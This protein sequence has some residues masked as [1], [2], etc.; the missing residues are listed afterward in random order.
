[1]EE[2]KT[3]EA[4]AERRARKLADI[5]S[6]MLEVIHASLLKLG[7]DLEDR[8]VADPDEP[9]NRVFVRGVVVTPADLTK[10]IDKVQLI[11][12]Q[13][14]SREEHLGLNIHADASDLPPD[15]L[16]DLARVARS[17]GAGA[18][19]VGQSPLPLAEGPIKVN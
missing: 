8:W 4:V 16:R 3:L 5:D 15:L 9:S 2:T 14:T 13:A 12:G 18:G 11:K 7:M 19:P 1:M 17:K 6:D 10:L